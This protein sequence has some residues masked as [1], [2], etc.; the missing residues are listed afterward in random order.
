M[1]I[2]A[3]AI[4]AIIGGDTD[5]MSMSARLAQAGKVFVSPIV[6]HEAVAGLVRRRD[7]PIKEA[8]GLVDA[9]V[10]ETAA[11]TME[12]TAAIGREAIEAFG[13]YGKGRH[14]A[15]LNMGDCFAYACASSLQVPLLF[16]GNGFVHTDIEVG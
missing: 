7:C 11:E 3:S 14:P 13:R 2:D 16:K 9:F 4:I 10:E 5:G 8:E 6:M 1:F 12:I 15:S